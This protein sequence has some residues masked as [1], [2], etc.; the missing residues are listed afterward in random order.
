MANSCY[1]FYGRLLGTPV[2]SQTESTLL[3]G[4]ESSLIFQKGSNFLT[5]GILPFPCDGDISQWVS[6]LVNC[7][8]KDVILE[9]Y[10][11]HDFMFGVIQSKESARQIIFAIG[12]NE[13]GQLGITNSEKLNYFSTPQ[14]VK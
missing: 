1:H 9:L 4:T 3:C 6:K 11:S 12:N 8:I 14:L 13:Y 2:A 7:S 10:S 5:V